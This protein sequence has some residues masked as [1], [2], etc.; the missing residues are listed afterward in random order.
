[1]LKAVLREIFNSIAI[2]INKQKK[3]MNIQPKKLKNKAR[4]INILKK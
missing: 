1:M 4:K 2:H 3:I